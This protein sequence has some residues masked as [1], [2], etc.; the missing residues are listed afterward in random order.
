M[1]MK[2]QHLDTV[3]LSLALAAC[4]WGAAG[5]IRPRLIQGTATVSEVVLFGL[6]AAIF[7]SDHG[8]HA[9]VRSAVF[10]VGCGIVCA[11]LLMERRTV[12]SFAVVLMA[13]L[14]VAGVGVTIARYRKAKRVAAG[15]PGLDS[16]TG[17]TPTIRGLRL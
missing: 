2:R 15:G 13:V 6:I 5:L 8:L 12:F 11:A 16:E 1:K 14:S 4:I 7:C 10:T 9:V 17:D 3:L